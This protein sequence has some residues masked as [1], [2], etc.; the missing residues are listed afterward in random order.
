ML[1]CFSDVVSVEPP[2]RGDLNSEMQENNLA[3]NFYC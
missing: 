3:L 1:D 2:S